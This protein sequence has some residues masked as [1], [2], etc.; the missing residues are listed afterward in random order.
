[1]CQHR[2]DIFMLNNN[3]HL[4]NTHFNGPFSRTTWVCRHQKGRTIL[5]FNEARDDGWQWHQLD[6]MKIIFTLL[7]ANNHT[8][9][10][11]LKIFHGPDALPNA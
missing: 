5:D 10:S 7:Q 4:I 6:H 9:T 2:N 1:M 3:T 11:S 8:S